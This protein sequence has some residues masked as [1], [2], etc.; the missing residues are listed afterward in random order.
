MGFQPET[1]QYTLAYVSCTSVCMRKKQVCTPHLI[2][3]CTVWFYIAIYFL[4]QMSLSFLVISVYRLMNNV[5]HKL[6]YCTIQPLLFWPQDY[7]DAAA[8]GDDC[9]PA[10]VT[11]LPVHGGRVP[12]TSDAR[13]ARPPP[14]LSRLLPTHR[15]QTQPLGPPSTRL[16][17]QI[18]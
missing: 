4:R 16:H 10:V 1:K 6:L 2:A 15:L 13:G 9:H 17:W 18:P 11:S 8:K 3:K 5:R 7:A 14:P 12:A